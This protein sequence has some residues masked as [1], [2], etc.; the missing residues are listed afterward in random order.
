MEERLRQA[1]RLATLGRMS[2]NIAH[3]IRNPLASLTGAIE[4]LASS[5]TAGEVRERLAQIVLK[6]SGRL[7]DILRDFLEYARPA[8][9]VRARVNL[10]EPIDE[11]LVLLEH[12][13]AAGTLK[14]AREFPPSLEWVADAQQ[15]RQAVWNLCLNAVEAMP[16]GGE[17][18]VTAGVVGGRLEVRVADTGEGIARDDLGHVFEPF[19]STK[20]DGSGLGLALVHRIMQEHGGEVH[21]EWRR[22]PAASSPSASPRS[23][24]ET[25]VLVVDDE[26]SMRELLGIM[27]RQ[28]GYAV[29]LADG[30]E[31]AVQALKT[32]DFDLVITDLRMRKVDGLAVLRAAKEHSPRTV[33]LVVTAFAST[34][35]AV[36]A[37]KLG[38]YDYVTKPF[39]LD[40]LRL[41]IA[42]ALELKR[43]QE[44][45]RELKRQLRREHGFEGFIGKSPRILEVFETIRKT[46]DSG[47]TVMIT[48]ESGTGKELVARAVHLESARRSGP[49]VSVT[50]GAIPETLMESELFGHVK[51]AFTG[52]VASTE[53]LFA[54]AGGGTL[55][56]DEITEIPH[57]VQVKLLR[58]TQEREVRRVGDTRDVKVDVRLIAASNRDLSKAMADGV[59]REDLYYRLNVIPIH[60]PPLRERLDDIPLLVSHF[61]RDKVHARTGKPFQFTR[62]AM[63]VLV[64]HHWPGNVRELEN[65]IERACALCEEAVIRVN[66]LP[67]AFMEYFKESPSDIV[68][69]VPPPPN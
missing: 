30:G 52:A 10:V 59:L 34:E 53:G 9:L 26:Q 12:R 43:L 49:F 25:R 63:E 37:M 19:F 35:T 51:G 47:S 2:A 45:N 4:V 42:N 5:G 50:C 69:Q 46:A 54:A 8:P 14:I 7:N 23:V 29:T 38:A 3:E 11:V 41:T 48:G 60:M 24:A 62:Q 64:A 65:A 44:E 57:S 20:P 31:A 36:E 55:F 68:F 1:D 21:V 61:I 13:A 33:V 39:K 6:E 18:R 32:D 40:E 58:A 67:P 56:L 28:V 66:D 17:L 22:A 15:F 16:D 27:L